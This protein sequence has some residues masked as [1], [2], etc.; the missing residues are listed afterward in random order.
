MYC[1]VLTEGS[2]YNTLIT[3]IT[4]NNYIWNVNNT[5]STNVIIKVRDNQ[6][7]CR[8]DVSNS[9]NTII[10]ATPALISPNG[11]ETWNVNSTH[12]ITWNTAT[13]FTNVCNRIF[14]R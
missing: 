3:N 1:T 2:S 7:I 14:D 12:N 5:P 6:N 9:A 11:G 8:K 10:A 13:F 4:G